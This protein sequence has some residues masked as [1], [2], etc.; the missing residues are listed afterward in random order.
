MARSHNIRFVEIGNGSCYPPDPVI[1]P[2]GQRQL[3][4]G[5]IDEQA[6]ISVPIDLIQMATGQVSVDVATSILAFARRK[7]P[8]RNT[9]RGLPWRSD[10]FDPVGTGNGDSHVKSID[11]RA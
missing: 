6:G 2:G 8:F 9:F 5:A 7:D 10:E 3:I 1:P 4:K 11:E